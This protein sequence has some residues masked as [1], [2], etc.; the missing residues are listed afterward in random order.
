MIALY[1]TNPES[2]YSDL[3]RC[4][5]SL[6]YNFEWDRISSQLIIESK[7]VIV[8]VGFNSLDFSSGKHPRLLSLSQQGGGQGIP[9]APVEML[10]PLQM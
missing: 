7:H 9:G 8:R 6:L 3:K 2:V 4:S 10:C 1:H 5:N